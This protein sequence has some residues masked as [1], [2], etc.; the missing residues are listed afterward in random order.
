MLDERS[1]LV[2]WCLVRETNDQTQ[3]KITR[4]AFTLIEMLAVMSVIS[5][6]LAIL[7]PMLASSME[8]AREF[9]CQ[10]S[11]RTVAF[12]FRLFA[13]EQ[14]HGNRGDDNGR[15]SF[16][17]ETFQ[18]NQYGV[19]EFWRWG[20]DIS[21]HET[22]DSD[23]NDPMRC[24]SLR[25]PIVLRDNLSCSSGAVGPPQ[26]VSFGF[27]ARLDRAE[28]TDAY[29][30]PVA[31]HVRLR[32]AILQNSSVPLMLDIDGE[33]AFELGV[34]AIY[35]A[36]SLDSQGPYAGDRVWFPGKRHNGRANVVFMDGHVEASAKPSQESGWRWDYQPI[37]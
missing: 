8:R 5:I 31:V 36:P 35:T 25:Q 30:R 20:D 23:G 27:N 18:E 13:D 9:K 11:Q 3:K 29:G 7:L 4:P 1:I 6:L 26:S 24:P 22:P 12:D 2:Q 15:H 33:R 14:L 34:P 28:I 37:R 16:D 19:D 32:P 17:L 21:A 10:M